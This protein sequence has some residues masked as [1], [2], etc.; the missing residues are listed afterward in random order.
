MAPLPNSGNLLPGWEP[1]LW[2]I[3]GATILVLQYCKQQSPRLMLHTPN[4]DEHLRCNCTLW[5]TYFKRI[6]FRVWQN[7]K[8]HYNT[9]P[10]T[11]TP[12]HFLSYGCVCAA[13]GCVYRL[14]VLLYF[15]LLALWALSPKEV[16]WIQL[17]KYQNEKAE[18]W[19]GIFADICICWYA[20]C[21]RYL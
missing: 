17:K 19:I 12:M 16:H 9:E 6:T 20:G 2:R 14:H 11:Q 1:M 3:H 5:D 18:Y 7:L 13:L 15:L 21:Y 4:W 10:V 8:L